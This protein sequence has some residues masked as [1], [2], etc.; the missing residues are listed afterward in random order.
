MKLSSLPPQSQHIFRATSS[1]MA[2]GAHKTRNSTIGL[3]LLGL[4]SLAP[5]ASAQ[6]AI[7]TLTKDG[8]ETTQ[9]AEVVSVANGKVK[10]R[11]QQGTAMAET[12]IPVTAL[13]AVDMPAPKAFE[14]GNAA[15]AAGNTAEFLSKFSGVQSQYRGLPT[16]WMG[17]TLARLGQAYITLNQYPKAE[18]IFTEYSKVFG[19]S[20][21]AMPLAELGRAQIAFAQGKQDEAKTLLGPVV[22]KS[23]TVEAVN[24]AQSSF[25]ANA[26]YT[27]GQIQEAEGDYANALDSYLKVVTLYYTDTALTTTSQQ[28]AD[29][30]RQA[31]PGTTV[32]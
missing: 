30:I 32:P 18:E 15:F 27:L 25:F 29:A 8:K 3:A 21:N 14:E 28:K 11:Y 16:P 19:N 2:P 20:S 9:R 12:E 7:L 22:E 24:E 26:F 4:L 5:L 10:V 17:V 13:A 31:H 1:Q 6:P 23:A